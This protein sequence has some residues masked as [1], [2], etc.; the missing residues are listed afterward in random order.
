MPHFLQSYQRNRPQPLATVLCAGL[1][2]KRSRC[3]SSPLPTFKYCISFFSIFPQL[4]CS[5]FLS[6]F[7]IA[8]MCVVPFSVLHALNLNIQYIAI[9]H[10][11]VA[12]CD[13]P[14]NFVIFFCCFWAL[15][16]DGHR[17]SPAVH[18]PSTTAATDGAK[19]TFPLF[20][21][22]SLLLL[23]TTFSPSLS[24]LK[25]ALFQRLSY[26]KQRTS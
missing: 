1:S 20:F 26:K 24:V 5:L 14:F 15:V 8:Y 17:R 22:H 6:P 12:S 4:L 13:V 11:L 18:T 2:V 10:V 9:C 19:I 7:L 25:V 21:L 3:L 23:S 16:S